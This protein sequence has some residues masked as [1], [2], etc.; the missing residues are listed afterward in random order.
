MASFSDYTENKILDHALGTASWT[1]PTQLYL[2][3]LTAAPSDAGGGTEVSTSGT[4][5]VRQAVD[6]SAASGGATSNNATVS[7]P[8]ATGSGFGTVTH[9]GLYDASSAGNLIAWAPLSASKTVAAGDAIEFLS[10]EI[11][12][13]LS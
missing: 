9:M 3:L 7:F 12:V 8:T 10:G 5:Y 2:G 13:T 4:A 11:D 1:M 6:F